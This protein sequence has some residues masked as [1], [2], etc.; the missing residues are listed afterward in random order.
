M[1]NSPVT[2]LQRIYIFSALAC[3]SWWLRASIIWN[4]ATARSAG[5]AREVGSER[6]WGPTGFS[7]IR[8]FICE[9][10]T[11]TIV[12]ML[13]ALVLI[14]WPFPLST[15]WSARI[16][17]GRNQSIELATGL[18]F[19][20]LIVGIAAGSYPAF[21][22]GLPFFRVKVL[23]AGPQSGRGPGDCSGKCLSLSSFPYL[24]AWS[25]A[26]SCWSSRWTMSGIW[27]WVSNKENVFTST[28]Q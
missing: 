8:Q 5:G 7:V 18:L 17:L 28:R 22:F 1:P 23:K 19:I 4:L 16:E 24:S 20:S 15:T 11:I 12:A 3:L 9:S 13:V 2:V 27:I 25:Y 21:W 6:F 10:V 14:E 26:P